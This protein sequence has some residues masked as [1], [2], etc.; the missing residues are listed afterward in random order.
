V[1]GALLAAI[2]AVWVLDGDPALGIGFLFIVPTMLAALWFG[3]LAGVG[4]GVA[5]ALLYLLGALV[6]PHGSLVGATLVRLVLFCSVGYAFAVVSEQ[7][8]RLGG[9]L[10]SQQRE[11][12]ELRALRSALVPPE[13]PERPAVDLATCFVPAQER[14]AGDFFVVNEGP[15]NATVVVV[16]DVVGKGLEAA[17]RAAFVRATVAAY[18]AYNDD[19]CELL[20]LTNAALVERTGTSTD[21][22]TAACMVYRPD[23]GKL[24][25][26]LAGHPP[27]M[28]LDEGSRLNGISPGLPLGLAERVDCTSGERPLEAGDGVLLFTDGL[29]EARRPVASPAQAGEPAGARPPDLFGDERIAAVLVEHHGE[30]PG[31]V[32]RALRAEAERFTAGGGLADDLCMVAVRTKLAA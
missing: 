30:G 19:P 23:E 26:A 20:E 4:V 17:R 18:A 9:R 2:A 10:N 15:D 32:V 14:V 1:V 21:F 24:S 13:V 28:L 6:H 22:V 12:E 8:R 29:A 16:G 3:P 27:P 5:G 11:L 7:A 25:W 31:E